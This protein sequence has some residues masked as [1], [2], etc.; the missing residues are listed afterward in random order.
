M[1]DAV[2]CLIKIAFF[3]NKYYHL[4]HIFIILDEC[5]FARIQV[6]NKEL[7]ITGDK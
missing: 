6:S 2:I 1:S 7:Q 4:L 3:I 5:A